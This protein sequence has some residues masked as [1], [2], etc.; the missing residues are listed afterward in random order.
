MRKTLILARRELAGY[1]LSPLAYV[2]GA[3]F[4]AACALKFISFPGS[5]SDWFVMVPGR[6][7]SLRP[8]F[9][10]M[11]MCMVVAAPA[12][13]MRL[14]V[15][16]CRNGT[17]E[18]LMTAPV[19]DTQVILG[20]FLGVFGF[21]MALLVGTGV[22]VVVMAVYAKPD[23]G[24]VAAGYL[25]MLLLGA[26][27]LSVGLFSSVITG[28]QTQLVSG[29]LAAAILAVF[30]FLAGEVM[31]LAP[32]PLSRLAAR[33]DVMTYFKDFSRGFI[34]SRGIVFFVTV[35]AL[36]LFASV[37]VLESRRWR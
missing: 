23:W 34:D 21:F 12:M 27:A 18:T 29:A 1:F 9:D 25:G 4:M 22:L 36:F 24:L 3:L 32:E 19:T 31:V 8:L 26:M 11:A 5:T 28:S 14:M 16:E 7:A 35:T 13:A 37:K 2:T 30:F 17:I 10:M 15:E 33:I 20:K 6:P